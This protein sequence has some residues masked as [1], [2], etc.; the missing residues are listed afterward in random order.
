M[1]TTT[2]ITRCPECQSD[3]VVRIHHPATFALPECWSWA[4]MECDH[5]WGTE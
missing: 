4:C 3:D 2:P 1:L 5:E